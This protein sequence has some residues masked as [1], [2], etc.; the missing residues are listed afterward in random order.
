MELT[1]NRRSGIDRRETN[2]TGAHEQAIMAGQ[3][4]IDVRHK[5]V[6]LKE[7]QIKLTRKEFDLLKLLATDIDRVFSDD[8]IIAKVWPG[9]SEA[10]SNNVK[11]YI[12]FLRKKLEQDPKKPL[13]LQTIK[14]FGYKLAAAID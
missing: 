9:D 1:K 6:Y 10:C 7:K 13:I 2:Q 14:G 4:R 11:Q 5:M 8:E 3:L 12:Y